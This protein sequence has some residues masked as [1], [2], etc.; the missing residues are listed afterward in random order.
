MQTVAQF[1]IPY[2]QYLNSDAQLVNTPPTLAHHYDKLIELYSYMQTIRLFDNK[3]I[4][5][6][7]TGQLGTF[8]STYGQ[9][10]IAVAMGASMHQDD[11]F[12]P[13]YREHGTLLMRGV[14]M[15]DI[16][17]YWG[18]DERG[19]ANPYSSQDFPICVPI[20]TQCTHAVG[21]AVAIKYRQ[22]QRAVVATVGDGGTSKGDFYEAL[23]LAGCWQLPI[24]FVINNNQWAISVAREQQT[25]TS[26]LA[27]KGIAGA[28]EG[29]QV[30]GNDIIALTT[31]VG[32]RLALARQQSKATV[33]EAITYRL[34]DHTTADDASRYRSNEALQQALA[35]EPIKRLY[36]YLIS[37]KVWD[38]EQEHALKQRLQH[39]VEQAAQSYLHSTATS[40]ASTM[41]DHL[42]ADLPEALSL[43]YQELKEQ[44]S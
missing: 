10:A 35:A 16:Y 3:A 6:Q 37:Q 25:A 26:T 38:D 4:T 36:N 44:S 33:I 12:A 43:Q 21:A 24:V 41:F 17:R 14:D 9:E 8:P 23:N 20:A 22:Q 5:L 39:T 1:N 30:D 11:I 31:L 27:Q 42:Y 18:G 15:S 7:R 32:E 28:V 40:Q 19:S 29:I 2:Y 34:G 13:Y